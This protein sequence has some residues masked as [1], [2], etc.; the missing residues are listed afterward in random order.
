MMSPLP[1]SRQ[2]GGDAH[3]VLFHLFLR[4]ILGHTRNL[5]RFLGVMINFF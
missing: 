2:V 3:L 5:W 1:L 4:E